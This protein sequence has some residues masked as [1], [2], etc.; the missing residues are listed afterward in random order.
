MELI[1]VL[2][3]G[4]VV[5]IIAMFL[6][7]IKPEYSLLCVIVGSIIIILCMLNSLTTVFSFFEN[8]IEKTGISYDLFL[9]MLKI[10]GIGY[11]VEFSANVCRD[12]G[13][14]SIADK[15]ILAGKLMIFIIS[16]PIINNLFNMVLDL[17]K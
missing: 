14:S 15:V 8:V 5:S 9:T 4:I 7:S 2:I 10:I 3:I 17:V 12:S 1:K 11:L 16:L 13:N 6:K